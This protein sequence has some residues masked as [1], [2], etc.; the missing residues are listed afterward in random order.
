[1]DEEEVPAGAKVSGIMVRKKPNGAA[2]VILNL[3]GPKGMSVNDG[4]DG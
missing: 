1:M 2:R 3:S 4:I